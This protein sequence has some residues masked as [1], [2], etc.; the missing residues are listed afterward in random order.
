MFSSEIGSWNTQDDL[1]R[2]E[3]LFRL[4]AIPQLRGTTGRARPAG[5]GLLWAESWPQSCVA[6]ACAED[7]GSAGSAQEEQA[8]TREEYEVANMWIQATGVSRA[9]WE[10]GRLPWVCS[11]GPGVNTG[12]KTK[13]TCSELPR[14][15]L[16]H[17]SFRRL[18]RPSFSL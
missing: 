1:K 3:G 13:M 12:Q 11:Q 4:A 9:Q 18:S 7:P 17:K 8:V 5:A 10:G 6:C 16:F 14:N 15:P 2:S